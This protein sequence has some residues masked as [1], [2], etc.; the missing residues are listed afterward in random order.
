M[1]KSLKAQYIADEKQQGILD[2]QEVIRKNELSFHTEFATEK[3]KT[4]KLSD[5]LQSPILNKNEE[6]S[7]SPFALPEN[8]DE[9]ENEE[10]NDR[11]DLAE[12]QS[13]DVTKLNDSEDFYQ[14]DFKHK[15]SV[16]RDLLLK[17]KKSPY[18]T[19]INFPK[20]QKIEQPGISLKLES[21]LGDYNRKLVK[22]SNSDELEN[23]QEK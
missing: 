8:L 12:H 20:V 22:P 9:G 6:E 19:T 16:Q 5:V 1:A 4:D 7:S 10:E 14:Q 23:N 2:A 3:L 17:N 11:I 15:S 18:K 13:P 21:W